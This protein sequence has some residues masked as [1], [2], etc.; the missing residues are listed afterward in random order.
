L[1]TLLVAVLMVIGWLLPVEVGGAN[2]NAGRSSAG[3]VYVYGDSLMAESQNQLQFQLGLDNITLRIQDHGG[4]ALC[5]WIPSI[6][7]HVNFLKPTMVV[8]EFSGNALTP[9]ICGVNSEATWLAKYQADLNYLAT[10][11]HSERVPL[12]VVAAP[13]GIHKTGAPVV[14]PTTW[15]VGEIPQGYAPNDTALNDM[16]RATVSRDQ[17]QG[18][19]IGYIAADK[20]VA[21][22]NGKWTYVLPCLSFETASMGRNAQGLIIVRAADYAHFCPFTIAEPDGVTSDSGVWDAGAWRYAAAISRW[23]NYSISATTSS[24]NLKTLM[25][26]PSLSVQS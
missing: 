9:C 18:W 19:D 1:L 15:T 10:W 12:V 13:P 3:L 20:A 2:K 25:L 11:L 6:Q 21:A 22:P 7:A 14:I 26:P 5:D 24:G 8:I 4:T 17:A 16:Y 23:V